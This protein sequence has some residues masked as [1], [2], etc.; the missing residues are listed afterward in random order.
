MEPWVS[1]DLGTQGREDGGEDAGCSAVCFW[2]CFERRL[3]AGVNNS[4]EPLTEA[5]NKS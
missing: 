5:D 4:K 3:Q 2:L 1:F